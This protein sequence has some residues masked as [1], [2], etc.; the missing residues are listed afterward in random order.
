MSTIL[1]ALRRLEDEKQEQAESEQRHAEVLSA[2]GPGESGGGRRRLLI[3]AASVVGVAVVGLVIAA[4]VAI[5]SE[6][7]VVNEVANEVAVDTVVEVD[8]EVFDTAVSPAHGG[9]SR[10]IAMRDAGAVSAGAA[11]AAVDRADRE[12]VAAQLAEAR[13]QRGEERN[14]MLAERAAGRQREPAVAREVS[15]ATVLAAVAVPVPTSIPAPR[16]AAPV[17]PAATAPEPLAFM[18]PDA[19]PPPSRAVEE[20]PSTAFETPNLPAHAPEPIAV[21]PADMMV[22]TLPD[23]LDVV[24]T[25][26]HPRPDRRIAYLALPGERGTVEF[27]EGDFYGEWVIKEIELGGVVFEYDG[28]TIVR[29]VGRSR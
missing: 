20:E 8:S 9:G 4:V 25:R 15:A 21:E 1:K 11:A 27:N 13:R 3:I 10:A 16:P 29:S 18:Q 6:P 12:A 7:E 2:A 28:A 22:V 17:A 5:R 14:R 26:W 24:R 19:P 23:D